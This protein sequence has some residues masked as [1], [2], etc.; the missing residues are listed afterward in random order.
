MT[1]QTDIADFSDRDLMAYFDDELGDAE[2]EP[3]EGA[4]EA[5]QEALSKLGG[6]G[7]IGDVVREH[8]DGDERADGIADAVMAQLEGESAAPVAEDVSPRPGVATPANDNARTVWTLAAAAAAV[9]A[10]LF[11]WGIGA[12][13][14]E[15][16][17]FAPMAPSALAAPQDTVGPAPETLG[18]VAAAPQRGSTEED[19]DAVEIAQLDFGDSDHSGSI[20][21]VDDEDVGG[22]TAVVWV[23]DLG[24]EE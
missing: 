23:N 16:V 21:K 17:A 2:R 8:V 18:D 7:F 1:K 5:Q 10:G 11:V 24:D 6:L 4:L 9:A 14:A 13:N 20:F 22:R 3:L 15:S 19:E 12:Q